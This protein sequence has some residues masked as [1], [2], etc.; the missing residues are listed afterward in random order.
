MTCMDDASRKV[1]ATAEVTRI[2]SHNALQTL[3]Q[4]IQ[5]AAVYNVLI[6]AVNTDRGSEFFANKQGKKQKNVHDF[7]AFIHAMDI[8]HIPSRIKNPQTNGKLER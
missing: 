8:R 3:K 5:E 1:L 2:T 7:V 6:H 4:G